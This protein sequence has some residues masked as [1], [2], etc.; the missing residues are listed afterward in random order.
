MAE[1]K[2]LDIPG[3]TGDQDN[4]Y[5]AQAIGGLQAL[6]EHDIVIMHVEAPD[7]ASHAGSVREKVTAIE[8]T[9]R[10]IVGRIRD[11]DKEALR[12]LVMPDHPTPIET[13]THIGE[14]VPF[15]LWGAGFKA[16]GARRFTETEAR[17]TAVFLERGHDIISR[18]T[19]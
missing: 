14:P 5:T 6:E 15:M 18:L 13:Q 17:S 8:L 1:M 7:E 19:E 16:N 10:E 9:D 12:V 3:V 11:W 2:V 4:D